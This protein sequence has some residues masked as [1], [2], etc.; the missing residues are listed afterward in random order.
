M[1]LKKAIKALKEK[2]F[3]SARDLIARERTTSYNTTHFLIKGLAELALE[4]WSGAT[5]T[6]ATATERFPNHGSFWL[7]RGIAEENLGL[8]DAAIIS[9]EKC[10]ELNPRQGEAYGNLS[11]LYRKKNRLAEA[12]LMAEKALTLDVP[13]GDIL[14]SLALALA[15]QGKFSAAKTTFDEAQQAAPDNP[16]ILLNRANLAVDQLLFEE[17][18][19]LFKSARTLRDDPLFRHDEG[20]ARLLSGDYEKGWNL[21]EA[22]LLM[23]RALRI[24]PSCP[25]WNGEDIKGKKLLIIAEQ[26]YGDVIHFCRYQKYISEGE[27]IW[28]VPK[29]LVRLLSENLSGT[30][31][32]ETTPL[33]V[34]DYYIPILSLPYVTKHYQAAPSEPYIKAPLTPSIPSAKYDKKIGLVWAGS[35]THQHDHERSIRLEHFSSLLQAIKADFYAPFLGDGLSEIGDLPV[36]RLDDLIHDFA[37]TAGLLKQFHCVITVDTA[38]AHLAGACGIKTFLLLAY[39]PDWRWELRSEKTNWYPSFTLLRQNY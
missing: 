4:D 32:D 25:R 18:W 29:N 17:A 8:Y 31:Y 27:L 15:R 2:D 1:L 21:F 33:P 11:N 7:N 5:L 9:Q 28:A 35:R 34:Y 20:L 36:I 37:D 39:C 24:Y 30:V 23:P 6:F 16:S 26:G 3:V 13:K 10:L 14:N 22:R 12:V 38:V 19:P